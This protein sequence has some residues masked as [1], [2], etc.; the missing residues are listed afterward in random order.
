M[1]RNMKLRALV[2]IVLMAHFV[3]ADCGPYN[4]S[5]DVE[6]Q[7]FGIFIQDRIGCAASNLLQEGI[8]DSII[9]LFFILVVFLLF[10]ALLGKR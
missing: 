8:V 2:P 10:Y 6:A 7:D 5:I 9:I 3:V 1:V 4:S